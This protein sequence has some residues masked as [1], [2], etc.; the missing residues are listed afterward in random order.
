MKK[1]ISIIVSF[2]VLL[3]VFSM[4]NVSAAGKTYYLFGY[5]N[6]KDYADKDDAANMGV[7]K[8][9]NN[10]ITVS[11]SG[12][13]YVGV[14]EEGNANWYMTNGWQG[15]EKT[16]VT[17]YNTN[18]LGKNADKMY[19]PS[20]VEITL[21]INENSDGT[22]TLWYES[23]GDS[24]G[25]IF[26]ELQMLLAQYSFGVADSP[27][28]Y[29]PESFAVFKEAYD[30]AGGLYADDTFYGEAVYEE[31]YQRLI[32]AYNSLV[33]ATDDNTNNKNYREKLNMLL[34][35]YSFKAIGME[36]Y[37][38]PDSFKEFMGAYDY[39]WTIERD[40]TATTQLLA[41]ACNI[42]IY[43]NN[44]L[45]S[46]TNSVES[47]KDYLHLAIMNT[48]NYPVGGAFTKDSWEAYINAFNYAEELYYGDGATAEEIIKAADN[49]LE[50]HY[51]LE[52]FEGDKAELWELMEKLDEILNRDDAKSLPNYNELHELYWDAFMA[53][54]Y[55]NSQEEL[56][57]YRDK[58][59]AALVELG[60]IEP[61]DPQES[62]SQQLNRE[63]AKEYLGQVIQ[64][65]SNIPVGGA[66][67]KESWE[68][69]QYAMSLANE[70]YD[71]ENATAD[72]LVQAAHKL[73]EA[74]NNLESFVGDKA[75]LWTLI[76]KLEEVLSR[77]D[78]E[79][80]PNYSELKDLYTE[81][82]GA[83]HYASTQEELDECR[84]KLKAA[85]SALEESDIRNKLMMLVSECSFGIEEEYYTPQSYQ[86][87]KTAYQNANKIL[88][89][90]NATV[91][92]LNKAYGDLLSARHSL[93]RL[94]DVP[95]YTP[96]RTIL[97]MIIAECSDV[98]KEDY[99]PGSY[100]LFTQA[101]EEAVNLLDDD[102]AT[103]E[104]LE[105]AYMSLLGEKVRMVTVDRETGE[106][107]RTEQWLA[108]YEYGAVLV[109]LRPNSPKVQTLL[110][111][112]NVVSVSVYPYDNP[113]DETIY[114]RFEEKTSDIVFRAIE[115]LKAS[116][117]VY[118]AEPHYWMLFDYIPD[119]GPRYR[120]E[121]EVKAYSRYD[122][123]DY[124]EESFKAY[125]AAYEKAVKL[126]ADANATDEQL[127]AAYSEIIKARIH[128]VK[129]T[130][131]TDPTEPTTSGSIYS[132]EEVE[133]GYEFGVVIVE[134]KSGPS[135]TIETLLADFEIE[136]ISQV[137]ALRSGFYRVEFVEKTKEIV[138]RAIEVLRA[139]PYVE[140]AYP[141]PIYT[142]DDEV[143]NTN[144]SDSSHATD[145]TES[146]QQNTETTPSLTD[147]TESATTEP[148]SD[149]DPVSPKPT[150]PTT[151]EAVTDLTETAQQSPE[152]SESTSESSVPTDIAGD[153]TNPDL[154]DPTSKGT[155]PTETETEIASATDEPCSTAPTTEPDS[156]SSDTTQPSETTDKVQETV[157]PPTTGA[158]QTD[159]PKT[160]EVKAKKSNKM[161]VTVKKSKTV[162]VKKLKKGKVK[163]NAI[164]VKNAKGKVSFKKIAKG[165]SKYLKVSAK[166][167]TIIV[168]KGTKKGIYKIKVKITAKGTKNYKKKTIIKTIKIKVKK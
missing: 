5:I 27:E 118:S 147:P 54:H 57:D 98:E 131:P 103:D 157:Q 125:T 72:Q 58:V 82:R 38:T 160:N 42:L 124:T 137:P 162:K 30:Y 11:F 166:K 110:S 14:K 45:V 86:N 111:D 167:G 84:D 128:L 63:Q 88:C 4:I 19:I 67:T 73:M 164:T 23:P 3:S 143:D 64:E 36:D 29:T 126:L 117:C 33:R 39:A 20:N 140:S 8:F 55:S 132:D 79:S 24:Y 40:N 69:Y 56:D 95:V 70:M 17:L 18:D 87:F 71:N 1:V 149:N 100:K 134:L 10:Q 159:P 116:S 150:E 75:E 25:G 83:Y 127:E 135:P 47:A 138:W 48:E 133:A 7:Y 114:V 6:G 145:P 102:S 35:I 81:A 60:E 93:V 28:N 119:D 76:E 115:V 46:A 92:Q 16:S 101:Y 161:K 108:G 97:A 66:W 130:E 151:G 78:A 85:L 68:A 163:V 31:A 168:K 43:A 49:L 26:E 50:A 96:A 15:K 146:E 77:D 104:Q 107:S 59:K 9:V 144:P 136:S 52:A 61:D 129:V 41:N 53:Y 32:D 12:D 99:A 37:Y 2:A 21:H 109:K 123:N 106:R 120:L 113:K 65:A 139:S 165:S 34:Y 91:D 90:D 122:A 156:E 141:S 51:C 62:S 158:Q 80:L 13:T 142:F 154:T 155:E 44:N 148:S 153:P 121:D 105:N 152:T 89:D 22:L 112:F 94:E 74:Y